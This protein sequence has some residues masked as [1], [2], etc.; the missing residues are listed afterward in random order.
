MITPGFK[1]LCTRLLDYNKASKTPRSLQM[2]Y[3]LEQFT[4]IPLNLYSHNPW[5]ADANRCWITRKPLK[6]LGHHML[7]STQEQFTFIPLTCANQIKIPR[8]LHD[9]SIGY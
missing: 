5:Y 3:T 7:Y 4:Y 8:P 1:P 2:I 6:P 9:P